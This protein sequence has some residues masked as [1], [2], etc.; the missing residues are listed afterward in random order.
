MKQI[1]LVLSGGGAKGAFQAGALQYID[2]HIKKRFPDFNFTIVSGVSVGCLNGVMVSMNR[3]DRLLQVWNTIENKKV[4]T[5]KLSLPSALLHLAIRSKLAIL[6]RKPLEKLVESLVSRQAVISTG[7]KFM[8]GVV[9]LTDG[10]YHSYTVEDFASDATFQQAVLAS[11]IMPILWEPLPVLHSRKG[12]ITQVVDGGLRNNSPLGDVLELDPDEVVIINCSPFNRDEVLITPDAAAARN[13]FS[14]AK[15]ALLEIA[16]NEIFVTDLREYLNLNY[17]VE[18]AQQKGVT[19]T[20]RKGKNLKA[21]KTALISPEQS[22]GDMLDF[23]QPSVQQR[24]KLGYEAAQK[25]FEH[26]RPETND[27]QLYANINPR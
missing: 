15:R 7:K 27:R 8:M 24:L 12:S 6:G 18:Q 11:G 4:Y 2:A 22:L 25:A 23:S 20:N 10:H 26:Y 16:M 13:V 3:L 17:L 1:A 9:S 14:I 21:Y 19:L 5:G